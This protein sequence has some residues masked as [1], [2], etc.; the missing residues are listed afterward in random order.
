MQDVPE[1]PHSPGQPELQ[2][3]PDPLRS[4]VD[5][6]ISRPWPKGPLRWLQDVDHMREVYHL[7]PRQTW[8][9]WQKLEVMENCKNDSPNPRF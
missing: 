4:P 3:M 1:A 8:R 7:G 6:V 2:Q 5:T 9:L